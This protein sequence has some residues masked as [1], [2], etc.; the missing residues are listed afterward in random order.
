MSSCA[1]AC[2]S[3]PSTS[4]SACVCAC[5]RVR[6]RARARVCLNRLHVLDQQDPTLVVPLALVLI[7]KHLVPAPIP[8][9][10]TPYPTTTPARARVRVIACVRGVCTRHRARSFDSLN[11][12]HATPGARKHSHGAQSGNTAHPCQTACSHVASRPLFWCSV[13]VCFRTLL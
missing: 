11:D 8:Y 4:F 13:F 3:C 1:M 5:V 9:H 12:N 2:A 6:A 10:T 7:A